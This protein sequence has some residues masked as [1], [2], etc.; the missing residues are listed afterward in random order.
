[1]EDI[2]S[3]RDYARIVI[4]TIVESELEIAKEERI[5]S[6]LMHYWCDEIDKFAKKTWQEYIIGERDTYVFSDVEFRDLFNNA[7]LRYASDILDGLVD[8]EM[9][10]VGVRGDGE[11]VYSLT[12]KGKDYTL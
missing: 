3:A 12:E 9:I 2:N 8:E 10:Q 5:D 7:G 1:M 4:N 11:L 6:T